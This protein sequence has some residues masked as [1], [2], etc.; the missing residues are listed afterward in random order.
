MFQGDII[1]I[2]TFDR[3]LSEEE[4]NRVTGYLKNKYGI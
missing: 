2:L 4:K 1:E 3:F